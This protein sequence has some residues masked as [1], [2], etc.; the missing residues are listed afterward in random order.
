MLNFADLTMAQKKLIV[1]Y[2][3]HTPSIKTNPEVTLKL[4]HAIFMDLAEKR[5]SGGVK[6]GYPNWL[7]PTNK[8]S[9][10]LYQLPVPTDAELSQYAQDCAGKSVKAPKAVV[11]KVPK[12]PKV[13]VA[14]TPKAP[15]APKAPKVVPATESEDAPVVKNK[16]RLIDAIGE[17]AAYDEDL[18]DFNAI[19]R[20]H[21]I[22]L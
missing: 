2:I 9:R 17:S 14:K 22:E 1:A 16:N 15:K 11:V 19:L 12:A 3:E 13:V 20:T 10:G 8:I 21:G 4:V 6:V 5:E 7:F 18:E